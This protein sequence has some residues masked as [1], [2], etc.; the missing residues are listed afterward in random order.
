MRAK[1]V[2]VVGAATF[3]AWAMR[4][5]PE[6]Y[7][8][9]G[10]WGIT[11]IVLSLVTREILVRQSRDVVLRLWGF[12]WTRDEACCHFLITGATGT[13]KTSRAVVP[14]VAGL[15]ETLPTTGIVAIDSKGALWEPLSAMATAMGQEE[16]LRLI[17][18][19]PAEVPVATWTPPLRLNLL[20]DANVPWGTYA[21]LL[22]DTATAAGQRGGQTFFKES[23]RDAITHAMYALEAADLPVTISN[24]HDMICVTRDLEMVRGRLEMVRTPAAE[25]ERQYFSDFLA[26]PPEQRSGTVYT[27]ANFLRPYTPPDIAEVFCSTEP[28]F[29]LAEVDQGRIVCLSV[30][31]TYQTERKYLNLLT[32]QLFFLH[33]FRRFDLPAEERQRRNMIVLVLDEGQKTTLVS[34]DGFSDHGAVDELREAGVCLIAATQ[35]PLSFHASF[36]TEK[37]ADVFMANLRTQIHFRAADE[38]GAKILSSKLGGRERRR[39]SG[40]FSGGRENRNWQVVERPHYL[41]EQLLA[42]NTGWAV[43]QHPR[44][45]TRPLCIRLPHTPHTAPQAAEPPHGKGASRR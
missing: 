31:Q 13:G 17:R 28:N 18:V 42:L 19:R 2:I 39:T 22:V 37:K 11:G 6:P 5:L 8:Y 30:P 27:V 1:G 7:R 4:W 45:T 38:K 29:S 23:A 20:V 25:R 10:M 14:I 34:E 33:A 41:S 3:A 15:R 21:K 43:V 40:G 44:R 24:V 26:Q 16:S 36:E 35:T 32:K 9:W 12:E